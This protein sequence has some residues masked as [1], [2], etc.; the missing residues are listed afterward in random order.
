[1]SEIRTV[2]TVATLP[3]NDAEYTQLVSTINE[4]TNFYQ[5]ISNSVWI[6][7]LHIN[8]AITLTGNA[9]AN[10]EQFRFVVV[11]DQQANGTTP[12]Y[13]DV[14]TDYSA[15]GGTDTGPLSSP[16][17]LWKRRFHILYD[18]LV[19]LPPTSGV[20]VGPTD[21]QVYRI[22]R[23]VRCHNATSTFVSGSATPTTNALYIMTCGLFAAGM[24][25]YEIDIAARLWFQCE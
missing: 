14:F 1:M 4:G 24:D 3:I 11:L 6:K 21:L 23:H 5:R 7:D 10:F 8:G 12:T 20:P 22:D 25:G 17:P 19:T 2:D 15:S 9:Q 18:E 16:N 13:A